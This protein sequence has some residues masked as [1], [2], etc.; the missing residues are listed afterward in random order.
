VPSSD[1]VSLTTI[2]VLPRAMWRIFQHHTCMSPCSFQRRA[3]AS[4]PSDYLY[5][6]YSAVSK[7]AEKLGQPAG[8]LLMDRI[9]SILLFPAKAMLDA[10]TTHAPLSDV[11]YVYGPRL[12]ALPRGCDDNLRAFQPFAHW[13]QSQRNDTERIEATDSWPSRSQLPY[14]VDPALARSNISNRATSTELESDAASRL[15]SNR[16][17]QLDEKD[18]SSDRFSPCSGILL[19]PPPSASSTCAALYLPA[20]CHR[21]MQHCSCI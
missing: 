2:C 5:R 1:R 6:L 10:P 14:K 8:D 11:C 16:Y 20:N 4:L 7:A 15:I 19:S 21:K 17:T 3:N 9:S 12:G 13:L 18:V